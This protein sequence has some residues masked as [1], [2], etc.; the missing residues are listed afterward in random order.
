L[1]RPLPLSSPFVV[2]DDLDELEVTDPQ[3][4]DLLAEAV[5]RGEVH[6][7]ASVLTDRAASA[8]RGAVAHAVRTAVLL[9]LEPAAAG[10]A[11]LLGPRASWVVDPSGPVGRAAVREGRR[12]EPLQVYLPG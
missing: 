3:S 5:V 7:L 2:V 1:P 9:V 4:A 12:V 10:S 8:F 11:D 6:L